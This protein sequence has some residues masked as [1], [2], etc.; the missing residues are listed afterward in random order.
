M[1]NPPVLGHNEGWRAHAACAEVDHELFFPVGVTGPAVPQIAAAKAVCADCAVRAACLEFAIVTN[2]EY[3]VWGGT[4]EEER[5][6]LRRAW[7][8]RQARQAS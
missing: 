4:S 2:Q 1:E 7:R 8:A 5:R 6:A 3:G